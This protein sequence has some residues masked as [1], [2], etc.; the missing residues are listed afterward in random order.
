ML[1][2]TEQRRSFII[3]TVYF[4]LV[5][6]LVFI[7]FKYLFWPAAPFVLSFLFAIM[8]QTP[9]RKLDKKT[10]NKFHTG[11]SII[12]ILLSI[13]IIIIPVTL[14]LVKL[15]KEIVEFT[16]YALVQLKDL[17]AF[18]GQVETFLIDMF[19]FLPENLYESIST[20]ISNGCTN[21]IENL[22]NG[23]FKIDIDTITN[24]LTTG[25]S[26]IY[27]AFKNVPSVLIGLVIGIVAWVFFTKDYD[28]I[29]KFIQYQFPVNKRNVLV[30]FKQVFSKT[31]L[32]MIKAYSLIMFITFCEL[33][34]GFS[35]L[36]MLGIMDNKYYV[37]IAVCISIFD[38]LPALGS[39]G[40]LIP[41]AIISLILGNYKQA[42]GILIIYVLMTVF[43]QYIEPK[44]V[45]NSLGVHPIVTLAGLYFG[46]KLFG[47]LG[48]FIVPITIMTLKAF[49][50]TGRITLWKTEK[51]Q[52][53]DNI[54]NEQDI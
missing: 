23:G 45:G 7:F 48:M 9:L 29:V 12:L 47:V 41:W 3:N 11:W 13:C 44:I 39:G 20:A 46:L 35:I 51:N 18:I 24:S 33:F 40:I 4:T 16:K 49:N 32:K 17:P 14:I 27:S 31:I 1:N 22:T 50:D 28:H 25:V 54:T 8:L 37:L 34:V 10:N 53:E 43:R 2:K 36:K 6:G 42:I 26:S 5:C 38:I 19:K 52:G 15:G 30:E 21:L